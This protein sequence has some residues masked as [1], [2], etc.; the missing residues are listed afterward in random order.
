MKTFNNWFN[1]KFGWFFTNGKKQS[2]YTEQLLIES[3]YIVED[4]K[5]VA[6]ALDHANEHGLQV[7][8][9]T[10]ALKYMKENP[11]LTI[12]EAVTLGYFEWIK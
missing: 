11:S 12:T 3:E 2:T 10:W 4:M 8:V 6:E 9:V 7:E 5:H 1:N